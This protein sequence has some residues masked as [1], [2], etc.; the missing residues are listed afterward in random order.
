MTSVPKDFGGKAAAKKNKTGFFR[1]LGKQQGDFFQRKRGRRGLT[2]I[3]AGIQRFT[4]GKQ[5]GKG[6]T[7]EG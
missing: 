6:H 1:Q 7:G 3:K 5:Q 4:S 2:D